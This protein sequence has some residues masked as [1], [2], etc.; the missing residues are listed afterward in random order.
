MVALLCSACSAAQA[1]APA[2]LLSEVPGTVEAQLSGQSLVDADR[3]VVQQ[4][5]HFT[6][7]CEPETPWT[8]FELYNK[9]GVLVHTQKSKHI[10]IEYLTDTVLA[11][12]NSAGSPHRQYRFYDIENDLL[13]EWYEQALFVDGKLLVYPLEQTVDGRQKQFLAM[14]Y[15]LDKASQRLHWIDEEQYMQLQMLAVDMQLRDD[16]LVCNWPRPPAGSAPSS[17]AYPLP[18]SAPDASGRAGFSLNGAQFDPEHVCKGVLIPDAGDYALYVRLDP[19]KPRP[20]PQ[21]EDEEVNGMESGVLTQ[22]YQCL[23]L[24]P[25]G[26]AI[27]VSIGAAYPKTLPQVLTWFEDHEDSFGEYRYLLGETQLS[28]GEQGDRVFITTHSSSGIVEYAGTF[29]KQGDLL[30]NSHSFI[31]G[32]ESTGQLFEYVGMVKD[33]QLLP[34]D[35]AQ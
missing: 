14:Q 5:P 26:S 34:V 30:L 29:T 31:N 13:T 4:D 15:P 11:I 19:L 25:D 3:Q 8:Y 17:S 35:A 10:L 24:W 32:Y 28:A 20:R 21:D 22:D 12:L 9:S 1:Q 23:G 7:Y 16:E 27:A 33:R 2:D 6:I 18:P